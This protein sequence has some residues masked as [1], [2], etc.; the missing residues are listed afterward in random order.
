MTLSIPLIG[1][2]P[3]E[4][5]T[6]PY[7]VTVNTP[8][9]DNQNNAPA[10]NA[11]PMYIGAMDSGFY[12]MMK[13]PGL[14]YG[15]AN[16]SLVATPGLSGLPLAYQLVIFGRFNKTRIYYNETKA[17]MTL[18]PVPTGMSL[19]NYQIFA[20]SGGYI[21]PLQYPYVNGNYDWPFAFLPLK[22]SVGVDN[23][24]IPKSIG[25]TNYPPGISQ[26]M[27]QYKEG[28]NVT[29]VDSY[30]GS[31]Y[32]ALALFPNG[33]WEGI[34]SNGNNNS[35]MQATYFNRQN[36]CCY[37]GDLYSVEINGVAIT[38]T[39]IGALPAPLY[40][41]TFSTSAYYGQANS[42]E[43]VS[44]YRGDMSGY[45]TLACFGGDATAKTN[46]SNIL[47]ASMDD[48]GYLYV[49]TGNAGY[50]I[51]AGTQWLGVS[52]YPVVIPPGKT[53]RHFPARN[54]SPNGSA[55]YSHYSQFGG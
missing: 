30:V 3:V 11:N 46:V 22:P 36:Y 8:F 55:R 39:L 38:L 50:G 17:P 35:R 41:F 42:N 5:I 51:V 34:P 4:I 21:Q 12:N 28:G 20:R 45:Y 1:T 27:L 2:I 29:V 32:K 16:L 14:C 23:F 52:K 24:F 13:L 26:M 33:L 19:L 48:A 49:T 54:A 47:S 9:A 40:N 53:F 25:A 7:D 15:A 10:A 31:T 43:T 37:N 6:T 18:N 44:L